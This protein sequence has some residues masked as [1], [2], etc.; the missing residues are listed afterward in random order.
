MVERLDRFGQRRHRQD[1]QP[2]DDG[3]FAGVGARQQHARHAFA[4]SGG[5]D[6]EHAA[7]G[8][9]R[10]VQREFPEHHD[11]VDLAALDGPLCGEDP[12]RNWQVERRAG[13]PDVGR[14]EIHGD[15]M[16]RKLESRVPDRALHAVPAFADAGVGQA[17]QREKG[18]AERDVDFDVDRARFDSEERG[19]PE[20]G[21][22]RRTA[23]K[24]G[25][26][27]ACVDSGFQR[28]RGNAPWRAIADS[29]GCSSSARCKS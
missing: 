11:V 2:L 29:A 3:R 28:L 26:P 24:P 5:G 13:L 21:E 10:P 27:D 8:M 15:A 17:D 16:R 19:G 9:N 23:C 7:R 25:G 14:R 6:R 1:L 22:H 20:A 4:P 12:E 18:Q